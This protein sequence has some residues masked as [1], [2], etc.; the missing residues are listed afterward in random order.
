MRT[1]DAQQLV[2][3]VEHC[4]EKIRASRCKFSAEFVRFIAVRLQ[5]KQKSLLTSPPKLPLE[6]YTTTGANQRS[7]L[8][9][10]R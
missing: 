7:V 3:L 1:K 8:P 5:R 10:E 2:A 4:W 6:F 9:G